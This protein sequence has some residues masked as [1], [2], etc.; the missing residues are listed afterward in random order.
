MRLL[1]FSLLL[2][3]A[4]L[5]TSLPREVALLLTQAVLLLPG[6]CPALIQERQTQCEHGI[7]VLGFPM[8]TRSFETGLHHELV[9]TLHT[10]R[11]NWPARGTVGRIV[12][13]PTPLLQIGHLLGGSADSAG[14][15]A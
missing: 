8:H 13:Q 9:T 10:S 7:D 14:P 3:K 15:G 5:L 12:H 1:V 2:T 6:L 11:P 4:L